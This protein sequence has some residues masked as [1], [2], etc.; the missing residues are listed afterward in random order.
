MS[1]EVLERWMP[2]TLAELREALDEMVSQ[3]YENGHADLETVYVDMRDIVLVK[4]TLSDGSAVLN[5]TVR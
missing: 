3:S 5:V 4:E 2:S 1:K